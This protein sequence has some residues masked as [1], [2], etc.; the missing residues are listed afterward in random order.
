MA[1]T[2]GVVTA[3]A[4]LLAAAGCSSSKSSAAVT[5]STTTSTTSASTTTTS[6]G[7]STT[8]AGSS[9]TV[10]GTNVWNTNAT[11]FRGQNGKTYT[12]ACTPN[13]TAYGVWGNGT[14]TD[15]SSIC[16]A[17]VQSGLITLVKGG[18][19]TYQIAAGAPSYQ[20]GTANGITSSSYGTWNGSYTFPAAPP[21]TVPVGVE[22]WAQDATAYRGQN[23]KQVTVVCSANGSLGSVYGSGPFTDDSSICTAAVFKGL[24]TVAQGG[25]VLIQ[26]AQGYAKYTA[27]TA[28]G[29]TTNA[30]GAWSGSYTF[31]SNQPST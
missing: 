22:T 8:A 13:G 16:T 11:A 3:G 27:G 6:A 26:I 30:Y 29:V 18:T 12:L 23:G 9:T 4:L 28:N 14:Y 5:T 19:V 25:T 10:A 31:P 15:D 7:S 20:A 21:G 17:A 1:T 24:M 2:L